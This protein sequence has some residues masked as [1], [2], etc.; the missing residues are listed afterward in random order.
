MVPST[1]IPLEAFSHRVSILSK[2]DEA[3]GSKDGFADEFDR[4]NELDNEELHSRREGKLPTN[5]DLNR[6]KN[7]VPY[8][9]TRIPLVDSP[10]K[11]TYINANYVRV[12]FLI[13]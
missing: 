1:S 13:L 2:R 9:H 11:R 3:N 10:S 4:L 7:I 5:A 6:Y 12:S 8:D